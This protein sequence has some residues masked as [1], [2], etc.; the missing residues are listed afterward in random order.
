MTM[1]G[2]GDW[3]TWGGASPDPYDGDEVFWEK[4]DEEESEKIIK[5][6]S[7]YPDY[8][9]EA[10]IESDAWRRYIDSLVESAKD[11]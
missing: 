1:Y 11:V 6:L 5:I 7:G 10:L 4:L 9:Y 8:L 2:Y 3:Q